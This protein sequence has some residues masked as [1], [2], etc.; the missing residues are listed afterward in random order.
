MDAADNEQTK[1]LR[2]MW[3]EMK[4]LN[5]RVDKTNAALA[6]LR[7]STKAGLAELRESTEAGLA[8]LRESTNAGLA[9]IRDQMRDGFAELRTEM[10]DGFT[11]LDSRI[12]RLGDI[13]GDHVREHAARVARLEALAGLPPTVAR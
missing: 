6:E 11:R 13:A 4:G 2:G 5:G 9:E 3:A 8:E 7:E 10:H 12:D 1:I